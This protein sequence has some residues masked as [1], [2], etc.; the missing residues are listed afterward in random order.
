MKLEAMQS[1]RVVQRAASY[2]QTQSDRAPSSR[3]S[4]QKGE[5]IAR[6]GL[7]GVEAGFQVQRRIS[8]SATSKSSLNTGPSC[9]R[10]TRTFFPLARELWLKS[11]SGR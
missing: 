3:R 1:D 8:A 4:H 7:A 10:E 6:R 11:L 9:P 2:P 5:G